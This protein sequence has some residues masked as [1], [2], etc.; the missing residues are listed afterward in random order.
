MPISHYWEPVV[1]LLAL[2]VIL[3]ICRWVFSTDSKPAAPRAVAGADYGLLEPVT[4]VRTRQDADMLRE[5][6]A[7]AGFRCTISETDGAFAVLVFRTDVSAARDLV[8]S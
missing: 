2:G 3:L 7:G 5:V 8:R 4:V 1:A 6:L